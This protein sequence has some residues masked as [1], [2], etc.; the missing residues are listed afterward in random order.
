[1]IGDINYNNDGRKI[2]AKRVSFRENVYIRQWNDD[3][4]VNVF[5]FFRFYLLEI[6]SCFYNDFF[7]CFS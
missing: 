1:M 6:V 5:F 4:D 2:F 3:D 7:F